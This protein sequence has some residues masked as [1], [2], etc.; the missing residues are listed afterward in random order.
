[1]YVYAVTD[2]STGAFPIGVKFRT[3]VRPDL[4]QVF[5]FW[6]IVPGW[7]NFGRQQGAIWRDMLLAEALF[8]TIVRR[9]ALQ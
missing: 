9:F 3:A 7:P 4:G 2:F 6:G 8:I 1:M 5:Y